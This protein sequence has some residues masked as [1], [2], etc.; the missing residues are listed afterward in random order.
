MYP[1]SS[2]DEFAFILAEVISLASGGGAS[3]GEV[4]RAASQITP[5]DFESFY[6]EFKFLAD[7]VHN[8]AIS[9]NA[10][11]SPA[12]ARDAYFRSAAYYRAADFFLHGNASDPRL[13]TLWDSQL[14]D[15]ES[16]I[17]LLPVPGEKITVQGPGYTIP[18][19]FYPAKQSSPCSNEK[20]PTI[21][22]GNGY[23]GSQ[24]ELYHSLGVHVLE[25]GWNFATYEGPGQETVRRQQN[26]G[27]VPEWWE[28]VTPVVDYLNTRQDVDT[29]KVA[30][31]GVSFGGSLAPRAASREHRLAA[32]VSIDGLYSMQAAILAAFP[33]ELVSAFKSGNATLFNGAIAYTYKA[34]EAKQIGDGSTEFQWLIDQSL[35]SFNTTNAFSWLTQ[36]GEFSLDGIYA[37]V[38]C[39]IFIGDG[40]H[41]TLAGTQAVTAW[42]A[43]DDPNKGFYWQFNTEYG[44]G[45]HCQIGAE[46]YLAMV[47][48][49]WL[50]GVFEGNWQKGNGTV[51]F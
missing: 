47:Y 45:E 28:V 49:D 24:E 50:D 15:Y 27:F 25:R 38:T 41:D 36:L 11:R 23:D 44:A 17:K 3:T 16:A 7:A 42:Q 37:N 12:S 1:L 5:G 33:P 40:Q 6:S 48:L 51:E 32:V 9:V 10:S 30:L 26:I 13:T 21:L 4:L 39:P 35:W 18:V 31:A 34:A 43:L 2:D 20:I 29:D 46:A 14:A 19:Y 8:M 22:A